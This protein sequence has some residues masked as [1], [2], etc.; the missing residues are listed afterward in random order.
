[1]DKIISTL[2]S[3]NDSIDEILKACDTITSFAVKPNKT[4]EDAI[5]ALDEIAY[6]VNEIKSNAEWIKNG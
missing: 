1:M 2:D 6:H 3:Y 4:L 5:Q